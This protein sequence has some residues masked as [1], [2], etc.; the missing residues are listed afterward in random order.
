MQP[1]YIIKRRPEARSQFGVSNST[2]YEWI[3]LG[4]MVPG[5]ALGHRSV[6][7]ASHELDAI[8]AARIAGK[9]EDEIRTLVRNLI[10]ARGGADS[11]AAA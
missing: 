6:G 11:L 9:S 4:L 5:V 8:A 1:S 3:K 10:A 7:Y 2:F